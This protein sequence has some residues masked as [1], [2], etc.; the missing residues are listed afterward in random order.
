MFRRN[1]GSLFVAIASTSG[2]SQTLTATE[3]DQVASKALAAAKLVGASVAVMV[4]GKVILAKG[5]GTKRAGRNEP[6]LASTPFAVGSVTKQFTSACILKL[7]DAGKLSVNDKLAIYFPQ[8]TSADNVTL[9]D[10]M[11]HVAGYPDYYPLDF[12]DRRMMRP[13]KALDLANRYGTLPLDFPPRTQWSYSNTDYILLGLVVEKVSGRSMND[14]LMRE[15][16]VPLDMRDTF[17]SPKHPGSRFAEGTM[18]QYLGLDEPALREGSGWAGAAGDLYSTAS[19]LLKW[20]LALMDGKVMSPASYAIFTTARKVSNG[21]DTQYAA[22]IQVLDLRGNVAYEHSGAVGG[23]AADNLYCPA[24]RM[25]VAILM[26]RDMGNVSLV[27][28]ALVQ[29]VLPPAVKGAAKTPSQPL[30]SAQRTL[31]IVGDS[32]LVVAKRLFAQLQ[33]GEVDRTALGE[34]FSYFLSK[35]R[36]AEAAKS[37]GRFGK[38]ESVT[39]SPAGERGGMR[40]SV[41]IFHF[42]GNVIRM[43]LYRTPDGKVQEF[44]VLP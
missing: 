28:N 31:T 22:G 34:E 37:L 15:I 40:V 18:S 44:L 13:I 16:F 30:P 10:L 23:F 43:L 2:F 33:S 7:A 19:D 21:A 41:P 38:P 25:A 42:P 27:M 3:A 4:D 14:F 20:D 12:V 8:M 26:N 24:N 29:R 11:N 35:G 17:Y 1:F 9:L 39:I 6:V 5:Y 32:D 36:L